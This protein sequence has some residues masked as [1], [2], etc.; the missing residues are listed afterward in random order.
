MRIKAFLVNL[1]FKVSPGLR[2]L[3]EERAALGAELDRVRD[4]RDALDRQF[5]TQAVSHGVLMARVA[6][7]TSQGPRA[8]APGI[9]R[10]HIVSDAV[11]A[12]VPRSHPTCGKICRLFQSAQ[13][14]YLARDIAWPFVPNRTFALST[15]KLVYL[16]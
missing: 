12:K 1:L 11:C 15:K 2:K 16:K 14:Q 8:D 9:R 4:D 5:Q 7:L 6:E 10:S 13:R 3:A